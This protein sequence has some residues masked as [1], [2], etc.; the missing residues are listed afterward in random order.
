M[1][2]CHKYM[3]ACILCTQ[4]IRY[5]LS[6]HI[7]MYTLCTEYVYT[8]GKSSLYLS[9]RVSQL[10]IEIP[11]ATRWNTISTRWGGNFIGGPRVSRMPRPCGRGNRG[12]F[13]GRG[14]IQVAG[15]PLSEHSNTRTAVPESRSLCLNVPFWL[16]ILSWLNLKA[17]KTFPMNMSPARCVSHTL[18]ECVGYHT[19]ISNLVC[20]ILYHTLFHSNSGE[21]A[22]HSKFE[23]VGQS[24]EKT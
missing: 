21:C 13:Q 23:C 24:S 4:I 16:S 22:G 3:Y 17:N 11:G 6:T 12:N 1:Y 5:I 7:Y 10:S 8:H 9:C 18:E 20:G 15:P 2:S 19:L 14:N